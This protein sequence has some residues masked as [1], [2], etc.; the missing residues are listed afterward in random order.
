MPVTTA[1]RGRGLEG[2]PRP[3]SEFELEEKSLRF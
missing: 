2:H 1:L 3:Y